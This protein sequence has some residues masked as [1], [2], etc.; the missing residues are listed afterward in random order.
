MFFSDE[1]ASKVEQ[2]VREKLMEMERIKLYPVLQAF[3]EHLT[4]YQQG[5]NFR[6]MIAGFCRK[7]SL[8]S[9]GVY[10]KP[11]EDRKALFSCAWMK[12]MGNFQVVKATQERIIF[13]RSIVDMPQHE[14]MREED[15]Y[16]APNVFLLFRVVI[17]I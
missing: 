6:L 4:S 15:V 9:Q 16:G 14:N 2:K 11:S 12:I 5:Q 7:F 1:E 17:C 8:V 10:S 3:A 13:D